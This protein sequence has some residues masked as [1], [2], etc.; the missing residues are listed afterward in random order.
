[1]VVVGHL[2]FPGYFFT[3]YTCGHSKLMCYLF[4][5]FAWFFTIIIL[6]N[7]QLAAEES[8]VVWAGWPKAAQAARAPRSSGR[9]GEG[10]ARKE[11]TAPPVFA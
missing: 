11:K 5:G 2:A 8:A 1:M 4:S 10:G 9:V 6:L 3:Q 7:K